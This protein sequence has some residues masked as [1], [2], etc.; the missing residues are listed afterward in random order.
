MVGV[1]TLTITPPDENDN[2]YILVIVNHFTKLTALYPSKEHTALTTA[3][4]LF[5]YFCTFGLVDSIISDPGSEFMNDVLTNLTKWFGIRHRFSLVDRHESNG[6]EHTNAMILRHLKALVFDERVQHQWSSPTILPLIQFLLNSFDNSEAGVIPFH[7]HFGS[8]DATYFKLPALVA[9]KESDSMLTSHYVKLL[10]ENLK[11]LHDISK[12]HQAVIAKERQATSSPEYQNIYQPGDFVLWQRDPNSPLPTKLSPKFVGP[13]LVLSQTKN[14]VS[15]RHVILGHVKVFHVSRLKIF[16]GSLEDAKRVAMIDNNQYVIREFKAYRGDPLLRTTM[17]FEIL[18]EDDSLV[19]LPWS[20]DL[21]ETIQYEAYCRFRPELYPLLFDFKTAQQR[22]RDMNKSA[23]TLVSPGDVVY[24]DLRCY[25]HAWYQTLPL[26]D[27]DHVNYLLEY[28]YVKWKSRQHLKI[29]VVCPIFNEVFVVN[30][31]F[32]FSYGSWTE[33]DWL[34][35][36]LLYKIVDRDL[37]NK[38]PELL[39]KSKHN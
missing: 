29:E 14:D 19:W 18:F 13:Y 11:L 35:R 2:T 31:Y 33:D 20:K 37:V 23:I 30:N 1:D 16:H 38:Y 6:V 7:A 24:V 15:C 32:V 10:D 17:E 26:E 9:G 5:Q 36:R 39:P 8:A 25:G 21:F 12:D 4:A 28:R 34:N 27:K 3:T 22:I